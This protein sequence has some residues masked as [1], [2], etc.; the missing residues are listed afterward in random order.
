[1]DWKFSNFNL[2]ERR[3]P[4]GQLGVENRNSPA[5]REHS[6]ELCSGSRIQSAN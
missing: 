2:R 5:G 6:Q 4:A 1:M 3:R